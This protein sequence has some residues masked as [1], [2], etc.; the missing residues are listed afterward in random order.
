MP[1][2]GGAKTKSNTR[3][4]RDGVRTRALT[5]RLIWNGR[6]NKSPGGLTKADLMEVKVPGAFYTLKN[7]KRKQRTR[8]ISKKQHE[9]GNQRWDVI[10]SNPSLKKAFVERQKENVAKILKSKK[11]KRKATRSRRV[12]K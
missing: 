3:K 5:Y 1:M 12:K 10:Q 11:P 4:S 2:Y 9:R 7:G 6:L 8:I